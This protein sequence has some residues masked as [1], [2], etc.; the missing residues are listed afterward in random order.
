MALLKDDLE[1]LRRV[2]FFAAVDSRRLRLLAFTAPRLTYETG[3][4]LFR[5]GDDGDSAFVIMGGTVDIL[6]N[7]DGKE[8]KVATLGADEMVGE[9]SLLGNHNRVATARASSPVD[10]LK[11][12]KGQFCD[13]VRNSPDMALSIMQH[14]ADTLQNTAREYA[15]LKARD[16]KA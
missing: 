12:K 11:L 9:T 10:V 6:F 4:D 7:V 15:E 3:E 5:Q 1:S 13:L 8:I 2:P 16:C 14:L